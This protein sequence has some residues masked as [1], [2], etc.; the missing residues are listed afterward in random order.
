MRNPKELDQLLAKKGFTYSCWED[1]WRKDGKI[2]EYSD[3][4]HVKVDNKVLT[5]AEAFDLLS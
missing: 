1:A 2:V 3:Y 5:I 4:D